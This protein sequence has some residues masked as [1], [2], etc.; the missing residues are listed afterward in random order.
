LTEITTGVTETPLTASATDTARVEEIQPSVQI[1]KTVY[2]SHNNGASCTTIKAVDSVTDLNGA[3]VTYCFE[4]TNNSTGNYLDISINDSS[5]AFTDSS[6]ILLSGNLPLVPNGAK[7]VYYYETTIAND[8]TNIAT[9]TGNPVDSNN[10]DYPNV[11][12]VTHSDTAKVDQVAPAIEIEKTVYVGHNSGLS[13]AGSDVITDT[14]G[15]MITYC[16]Y[17][18]NTGDTSLNNIT[19]DDS[20]LGIDQSDMM[21]LSGGMPLT[22]SMSLSYYYTTTLAA[23]LLNTATVE[24]N[25][26][27][28]DGADYPG[29]D[30]VTDSDTAQVY[31]VG[32]A[33]EVAKTVY[34]GTD[35][36]VS[37]ASAGDLVIGLNGDMV[38]Y[39]FVI[40]NTGNTYLDDI[41][42]DDN[43]LGLDEADMTYL[44]GNMRLAPTESLV[45]YHE[46]TI[47]NDITNTVY[48][49]ANPTLAD[50]TDLA[51]VPQLTLTD[52]AMVE[53][54]SPNIMLDKTVSLGAYDGGGAS[55]KG[56]ESVAAE[57]GDD[58]T[59]CFTV[60][61]TGDTYLNFSLTDTALGISLLDM[62]PISGTVPLAAGSSLEYYY[63][64]EVDGD[65]VN[66]AEVIGNPVDENLIDLLNLPDVSYEDS[67]EVNEV[68]PDITLEKTV[69]LGQ[70][71]GD[72]CETGGEVVMA[73]ANAAIT[74]CFEVS[75]TSDT[76]LEISL[77]DAKLGITN[78]TGLLPDYGTTPL[79]AGESRTYFYQTTVITDVLN[80]ATATGNPVDVNNDDLP[81]LPDVDDSNS[82]RV[83]LATPTVTLNKTV[84]AG[85]DDGASCT[86][87]NF[88]AAEDNDAIT[89]CFQVTNTGNTYLNNI[90]I[91]DDLL[92]IEQSDLLRLSGDLPLAPD[93]SLIYY[94]QSFVTGPLLNTADVTANPSDQN[95]N[96]LVGMTNVTDEDTAEVSQVAP[97]IEIQ[98]T[99][100]AGTDAAACPGSEIV[101]GEDG[102]AVT[103]C[104]VITNTGDTYLDDVTFN[105]ANLNV[106]EELG[107]LTPTE[108]F[109]I[110]FST[111][112]DGGLINTASVVANPIADDHNDLDGLEDI[113]DE[114]T[115]AV[116][117]AEL[118][119]AKTVGV[120][121][122]QTGIICP[123][124][125]LGTGLEGTA[126]FYCFEVTNSGST[127]LADLMITDTILGIDITD[128]SHITGTLPLGPGETISYYYKSLITTDM[129]NSATATA[130]P[131]DVD[132]N[133]LPDVDDISDT[134]TATIDQVESPDI[135]LH[136][137]VYVGHDSGTTCSGVEFVSGLTG[138]NITYCFEVEN[139]GDT[140]LDNI[141]IIDE[142]LDITQDQ[143]TLVSGGEPLSP[144]A[145]LIYYY[146]TTLNDDLVNNADV[147]GTPSDQN[148]DAITGLSDVTDTDTATVDAASSPA[149][150]LAKTVYNGN[151]AGAN[152]PG[153]ELVE[154]VLNASITYCFEVQNSGDTYLDTIII[155]DT[156]LGI[157]QADMTMV[158]GTSPLA[159][160]ASL[161]YIYEASITGNMVNTAEV[162]ANPSD[163]TGGDLSDLEN[164]TDS[165]TAQV[166]EVGTPNVEIHKTVYLGQDD[167]AGCPGI[168]FVQAIPDATMTYCFEVENTGDTYLDN[169]IITEDPLGITEEEMTRL[170]SGPIAPGEST[171]YYYQTTIEKDLVNTAAVDANPID[172]EGNDI[173]ELENVTD[174]DTAQV[175][176]QIPTALA[177]T[178]LTAKEEASVSSTEYWQRNGYN[179]AALL[180]LLAASAALIYKMILS[181]QPQ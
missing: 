34:Y 145:S 127:Y 46:I 109:P 169:I 167:G 161:I 63:V 162:E 116:G 95:G 154:G 170:G 123:A 141:R 90:A 49:E 38:T 59:F 32:P 41:D 64:V 43:D 147:L 14:D 129:V 56:S 91:D 25:P 115:A 72:S 114:D 137:T 3:E 45:Y 73:R 126:I 177:L 5:L 181:K 23:N 179:L 1:K 7:A 168:E 157:T 81:D 88:I 96:D 83:I 18:K 11:T 108:S 65:F 82:A 175:D 39:C 143:M 21:T 105:D 121:H 66:T 44:S 89:Y 52:T 99:V 22:P 113:S 28:T 139:T 172:E 74:Y 180:M 110:S 4:V 136:K 152:C 101:T 131:I 60:T 86:G 55:C 159:P 20:A 148:G 102:D 173:G 6:M 71:G 29:M 93:E 19:I 27:K 132:G 122:P 47:T 125:E 106:T 98:K 50:G 35:N 8:L 92:G 62:T 31:L 100:V 77:N 76:Y 165:D 37:C 164:V 36:G 138:I 118:T 163:K 142:D 104:F 144:T 85:V 140:F 80:I 133:D 171:V 48:V 78:S 16:F 156:L 178:D 15:E 9:V 26:S 174:S 107:M 58:V 124:D 79:P 176:A 151:D 146:E 12:D 33:I 87:F 10:N 103:Y 128:M 57:N 68:S 97:A 94:Y 61:N 51:G 112:I 17:V 69:Y 134:D 67:A 42:L 75:N 135:A 149:V 166:N 119:L 2:Q 153:S 160:G 120:G 13:C 158:G 111:F 24:G 70:N 53:Q 155:T 54:V 84:Y 150:R 30:N 130:N 40:K 117:Q